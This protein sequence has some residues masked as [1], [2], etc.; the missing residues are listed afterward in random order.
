MNTNERHDAIAR[1][2]YRIYQDRGMAPGGALQDWLQAEKAF[3]EK[4]AAEVFKAAPGSLEEAARRWVDQRNKEVGKAETTAMKRRTNR[5]DLRTHL[6]HPQA[7]HT[8]D[9]D[10]ASS[11]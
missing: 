2:A 11:E 9:R 3:S 1:E 4:E 7:R 6:P 8:I 5:E 10:A